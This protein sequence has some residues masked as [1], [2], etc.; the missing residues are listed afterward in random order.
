MAKVLISHAE[1][2]N[3]LSFKLLDFFS[4]LLQLAHILL[5]AVVRSKDSVHNFSL[6]LAEFAEILLTIL[7]FLHYV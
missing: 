2:I 4:E 1:C 5:N 6:W 3:I 7:L